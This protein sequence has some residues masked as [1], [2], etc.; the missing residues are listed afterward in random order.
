[1]HLRNGEAR[2]QVFRLPSAALLFAAGW[3]TLLLVSHF[4]ADVVV[5]AIAVAAVMIALAAA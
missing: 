3:L 2:P 1:M 4:G 5:V